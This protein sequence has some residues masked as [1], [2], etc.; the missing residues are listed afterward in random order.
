MASNLWKAVVGWGLFLLASQ[1]SGQGTKP[2]VYRFDCGTP[3][4]L[5]KVGWMRVTHETVFTPERGYG[6]LRPAD[7]SFDR[8]A[9]FVPDWLKPTVRKKF[10]LDNMLR[11]GVFDK[12][13]LTFRVLVPDGEYWLVVS[14][15]DERA[16]RRNMSVIANGVVIADR[17]TTQTSWGGY[18]T[19]RTFRQRL[20]V[21]GGR[22]DISFRHDGDGNSVLGIEV[23][24]FVPYP[25][26]FADG[27]WQTAS[28]DKDLRQGV[29]ALN[30]R[31]WRQAQKFFERLRSPLMRAV[32]FAALANL[33]DVPE[34]KAHPL[35]EQAI[36]VAEHVLQRTLP[37]APDSLLAYELRRVA[38][39]Y[40]RARRFMTMLAY[41]HAVRETGLTFARR[42]RMAEDWLMQI[43]EDDPLFDRAALNLGRIHYWLWRE[44]GSAEEKALADKWFDALKK[45]QPFA[46]LVRLYTGEQK[47]WGAEYLVGAEG[48]PEWAVKMREAM[49]RLLSV[50]RWWIDH[51]QLDNGELGGG[52]GDD[53]EMLRQWHVFIAGADDATVRRGWLKLAHGVWHSG[54]IDPERGYAKEASDV[55]HSAEPIADTHPAMIGLDHGNPVW[56][57]RCMKTVR[58][59]RDFW[60]GINAKGHRHF[61]SAFIGATEMNTNPPWGVDVPCNGRATRAGLWLG[62][63]NRNPTVVQLFREWMDAWVEDIMREEN[64]KPAGVVPPAVAFETDRIGGYGKNWH[65]PNLYWSYFNWPGYTE[66]IY[67]HLLAVYDWTGDEKYLKPI[68]AAMALAM[69][70]KRNPVPDPPM[71]SRMWVARA[72]YHGMAEVIGKY[73]M[74]TGRTHFDDYLREQGSPYMRFLLTGDKRAL[75]A[76][77]E[78]VAKSIRTNFE[79]LTSEVLFTD[80]VAVTQHPMWS[81]MTGGASLPYFYPCYFVTWQNTGAHFAA[82]VTHAD[83]QSLKVL[84]CHFEPQPKTV[85]MRLWRLEPG[86]YEVRVGIDADGDDGMDAVTERRRLDVTERGEGVAVQLLPR[87][88]QVIEVKKQSALSSPV[89]A[90]WDR[91]DLAVGDQDVRVGNTTTQEGWLPPWQPRFVRFAHEVPVIV[92]VYNIG[93]HSTPP[94]IVTLWA[95]QKGQWQ[96]VTKVEVPVLKAPDDLSPSSHT[97]TLRWR[98]K[99]TGEWLLR[100]TV[101]PMTPCHEITRRNNAVFFRVRLVADRQGSAKHSKSR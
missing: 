95:Q 31:D 71:G 94:A 64:G 42:L 99:Q 17:V 75:I 24:P 8:S 90:F 58:T 84:A 60:T 21:A 48:M 83:A 66:K 96:P 101:E 14:I 18:A 32:A 22:L 5:L 12:G 47:A 26:R 15:G 100:V 85:V 52:Y 29:E 10:P 76:A 9:L 13:E 56:V 91:P 25:I 63:Y 37:N 46:Q 43:T 7:T 20:K 65:E 41:E 62:W 33:L 69:E 51:R 87:R 78:S 81:M 23:V 80:R 79:L 77:C 54:Y 45:R 39:N 55:Q 68:E 2:R 74:L 40:L 49:G 89:P 19:T 38:T 1:G 16:T 3:T 50:L 61:K 53:V 70:W 72:L 93:K 6:W 73:R 86:A 27:K 4:S 82:L 92:T 34:E 11:D 88:V 36:K 28:T 57:E 35:L 67:D 30:R 98:P 97:V 59:M 44:G